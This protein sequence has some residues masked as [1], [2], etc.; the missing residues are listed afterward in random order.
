MDDLEGFVPPHSIQAEQ[1]VIGGVL[2]NPKAFRELNLRPDDFYRREHRDIYSAIMA[3]SLKGDPVDV[4]T[5]AEAMDAAGTLDDIGGMPYLGRLYEDTPSAANIHAYAKLVKDHA[6]A[7]YLRQVAMSLL[8]ATGDNWQEVNSHVCQELLGQVRGERKWECDLEDA[9][10]SAVDSI[11]AAHDQHGLVGIPTGIRRL[12]EVLGGFH[13]SDLC[14]IGARPAMGKTAFLLNLAINA[15]APFG[16]VSAEMQREQVGLRLIARDGRI[17]STRLRNAQL[18]D[19]E[20]ARISAALGRLKGRTAWVL[21]KPAPTLAD[22]VNFARRRVEQG[23]MKAL[24]ID[25]IQR[26]KPADKSVPKHE[27]VGEIVMGLKELAREL[28]I[29]V[30]ALAQVNREVEKRQDRRP[31]MGDLKHSGDIEQEAD[32]VILLYRDEVYHE[33]TA[34]PGVAEVR[35]DKNRHGPTGVVKTAWV[36]KYMTFEEL[37]WPAGQG[38]S[39]TG[40][41][42]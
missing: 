33:D 39:T 2:I 1:A 25:Y 30:I 38:K 15:N 40:E 37:E 12:D 34:E 27:Q 20:W 29:P 22:V 35:V 8:T 6:E 7:R 28:N 11:E 19:D 18:E 32:T 31:M 9:L 24:Y 10:R 41:Q 23:G 16:I 3:V 14:V 17:D 13:D 42:R 36:G 26:M 21:D 4:V 5:I